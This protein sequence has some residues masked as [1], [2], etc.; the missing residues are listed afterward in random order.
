M[1]FLGESGF[2]SGSK[3]LDRAFDVMDFLTT[4][5]KTQT[6]HNLMNKQSPGLTFTSTD[7]SG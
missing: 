2:S 3:E 5:S 4:T 7:I 1:R 6:K